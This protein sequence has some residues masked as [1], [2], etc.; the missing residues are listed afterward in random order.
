MAKTTGA[1][2]TVVAVLPDVN[3]ALEQVFSDSQ[4]QRET[5]NINAK[6]LDTILSQQRALGSTFVEATTDSTKDYDVKV[7]W[8]NFCGQEAEDCSTNLCTVEPEGEMVEA[9]E[10]D[11][12]INSC[13]ET[14]FTIEEQKLYTSTFGKE[15]LLTQN[16]RNAF[17]KLLELLNQKAIAHIDAS[18]GYNAG[19]SFPYVGGESLI[20][21]ASYD[22]GVLPYLAL[23]TQKSLLNNVFLLDGGAMYIPVFNAKLDGANDNGRGDASRAQLFPTVFDI[24]GMTKA[25]LS[26]VSYLIA[27]YAMAFL[28]KNYIPETVP[29][30]EPSLFNGAG[31]YK[32][33]MTIPGYGIKVDVYMRRRCVDGAKNLYNIDWIF[34]LHYDF[35]N[36]PAGCPVELYS[37]PDGHLGYLKQSADVWKFNAEKGEFEKIMEGV[38]A[39]PPDEAPTIGDKYFALGN[40]Y[41]WNGTSW[42]VIL[43]DVEDYVT[44]PAVT[45]TE[46]EVTGIIKYVKAA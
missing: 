44:L 10:E 24:P 25:G 45:T 19:G 20:P 2:G 46:E 9:V 11:Y 12:K 27:D 15:E 21:G 36:S 23:D 17:K 8:L 29:T 37:I 14:N 5:L 7:R 4:I 18:A 43:S 42:E 28:N 39:A 35:V 22:V 1:I 34:K 6:T 41:Q 30:F 33:H 26:N 40:V 31:G 13:I 32:Y 3:L 16:F 38:G